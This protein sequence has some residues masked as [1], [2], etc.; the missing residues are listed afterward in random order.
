[1]IL[2]T[3]ASGTVGSE[4]V[5]Q[6][7]AS[8]AK[9]RAAFHSE[10][11]ARKA[12]DRGIDAVVV[13]YDKPETVDAALKGVDVLFLLSAGGTAQIAQEE[14]AVKA[15]KTAGVKHIVKL[16]AW[17]TETDSFSFAHIHRAA[18]K[19]IEA[20]GLKW[21][22]LRPNGFM[23]N[24]ANYS[25]STIKSQ[26]AIYSSAGDSK[27]SVIDVRDVAAVAVKVLTNPSA[28]EGKAYPLS[29]PEAL[30]NDDFARKIGSVTGKPVKY[31]PLS[32]ADYKGGMLGAGI[33]SDYA[34]ALL[35]LVAFYKRGGASKVTGD[36]K[37][38]I[39]RDPISFDQYAKDNADAFR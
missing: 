21:T 26:G 34:D 6:L 10:E 8:G 17:G 15:A 11:K 5:R 32:D 27:T 7:Q 24:L 29:G 13:D 28:H 22:F 16:S 9:F 18:E 37:K 25:G 14:N 2:V 31:V 23:Q 30:S 19:A 38:I 33:P 36:V 3:G 12:R 35:D 4:V 20:S 39:G 1:M